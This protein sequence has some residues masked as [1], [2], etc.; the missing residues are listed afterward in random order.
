VAVAV[1]AGGE[2]SAFFRATAGHDA[3]LLIQD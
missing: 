1:R 2:V 3:H